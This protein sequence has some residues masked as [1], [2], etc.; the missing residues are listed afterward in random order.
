RTTPACPDR[1]RTGNPSARPSPCTRGDG[2]RSAPAGAWDR[3]GWRGA[4]KPCKSPMTD[5]LDINT[6][7]HD[8]ASRE[9]VLDAVT[10]AVRDVFLVECFVNLG[11]VFLIDH[12]LKGLDHVPALLVDA[13]AHRAVGAA[14]HGVDRID[15]VLHERVLLPIED[16]SESALP[17]DIQ[18]GLAAGVA[19]RAASRV[20]EDRDLVLV[21]PELLLQRVTNLSDVGVIQNDLI[22]H[23]HLAVGLWLHDRRAHRVDVEVLADPDRQLRVELELEIGR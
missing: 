3:W 20:W 16:P 4:W 19:L 10:E 1:F 22:D 7:D 2:A 6:Q 5:D 8:L 13:Q 11:C 12:L 15:A 23:P 18:G 21:A 14:Q 9:V 17:E